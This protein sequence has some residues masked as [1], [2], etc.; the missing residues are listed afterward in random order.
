MKNNATKIKMI[1]SF[2]IQ[3]K[4]VKEAESIKEQRDLLSNYIDSVQAHYNAICSVYPNFA[5]NLIVIANAQVAA[6]TA[7]DYS[8][9]IWNS[10]K[11]MINDEITVD[12]FKN[13]LSYYTDTCFA[14]A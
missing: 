6:E 7:A 11:R 8:M 1:E 13:T 3:L 10:A 5:G 9:V 14:M 4:N 2:M 12:R